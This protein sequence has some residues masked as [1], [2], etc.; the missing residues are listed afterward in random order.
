[1]YLQGNLQT[2]FDA[3]YHLGVIDPVLEMDWAQALDEMNQHAMAIDEIVQVANQYQDDVEILKSE[4]GKFDEKALGY[5][6]MEVAREFAD[7]HAREDLH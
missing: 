1:M 5:L 7:F 4:L 2:V 6:A 3:L